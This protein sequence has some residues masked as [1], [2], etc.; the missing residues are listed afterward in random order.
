MTASNGKTLVAIVAGSILLALIVILF[1][2]FGADREPTPVEPNPTPD[3]DPVQEFV[4]P[5]I[6]VLAEEKRDAIARALRGEDTAAGVLAM[7]EILEAWDPT[8]VPIGVVTEL[9][10]APST[11][12][13]GVVTYSFDAGRGGW[14]WHFLTGPEA[15][16]TDVERLSME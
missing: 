1:L 15:T 13:D 7:Q 10:G 2:I 12:T 9:L 14:D 6:I 8:G 11:E 4:P 3:P 16:V 5:E